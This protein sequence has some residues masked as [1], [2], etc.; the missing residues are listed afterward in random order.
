M[1]TQTFDLNMIPDSSPV[2]VHVNQYD[3]GIGRLIAKLYKGESVYTPA[4]GA[5]AIIQGTKPDGRGF[6]Y[7]ASLSGNTVTAD[8]T[9]QMAIAAGQV[10]CQIV[11]QE[12]D[13]V[14]GTFVFILEVQKSA[15]PA[16]TDMSASE[17]SVVM[18]LIEIAEKIATNPP[19]IGTNGNWWILDVNTGNYV[20]SGIDASITVKIADIHMLNPDATPYVTNSGTDTDPIFH[21]YIPRGKGISEIEKIS[22]SGLQDTYRITYSDGQTYTFIVTNGRGISSITKTSTSGRVDTYTIAYNSGNPTTFTVT[23]G[24]GITNIQ[25]TGTSGLVDTYTIYY[26]DGDPTTFSVTNGKSAYQSA[27]E[28]GYTGTEAEFEEDLAS[29]K[30]WADTA[31]SKAAEAAESA[32]TATTKAAQATASATSANSSAEKSEAYAVGRINGSPVPSSHENY[33]NNSKYYSDQ[34]KASEEAAESSSLDSEAY[35]VGT[36]DGVDVGVNDPA[37]RNNSKYYAS[38][39][40]GSAA[41]AYSSEQNAAE[42]A[43]D[44][45]GYADDASGSASDAAAD[46]ALAGEHAGDAYNSATGASEYADLSKSYA[47]GT[48]GTIRT[49]DATDNSKY[50]SEQA[51]GAVASANAV[52]DDVVDAGNDALAAIQNALDDD[53]PEFEI[54]FST[55]HLMY[56]GTR[57]AFVINHTTGH[58]MWGLTI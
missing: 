3:V 15:L 22:T 38:Q 40:S 50:Y 16:D 19:I 35:A 1:I 11:V 2:V 14:T 10:R 7:N 28:G 53:A 37:Y 49:G 41:S 30:E 18:H 46:A 31:S 55:G 52:L 21:L 12:G 42:S 23:N 51:A 13:N 24:R 57:F 20:D 58:L 48:N 44:A 9:E 43:S 39:A 5:T 8:I 4:A 6:N 33:H 54:N 25:K 26:N 45:S 56:G 32:S 47:V 17:Y 29:F 34:A 36:R 27:V